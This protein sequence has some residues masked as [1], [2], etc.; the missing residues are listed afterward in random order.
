MLKFYLKSQQ[1]LDVVG[2][3]DCG[4]I[5]LE[6]TAS[7][8]PDIVLVDIEM[9]DMD[10]L[11]LT[12]TLSQHFDKTKVMVLSSHDN[13]DYI[14]KALVAGAQGYLLKDTPAQELIHA[15]RFVYRG[16]LQLGSGL[17]NKLEGN[18]LQE[19]ARQHNLST[20][21]SLVKTDTLEE[22]PTNIDGALVG[23]QV[24]RFLVANDINPATIDL[25]T[26]LPIE[27]FQ[28]VSRASRQ[29]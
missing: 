5:A 17:F 4:Q 3:A 7:L 20:G 14:R 16:D 9:P 18:A 1:D 21:H 22:E 25:A 27:L 24:E 26:P 10:G 8:L 28:W 19:T 29:E 12:Q 11:V 6:L 15:I 13:E 2:I 23:I